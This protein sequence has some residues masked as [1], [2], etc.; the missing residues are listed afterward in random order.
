[1][2]GA[3]PDVLATIDAVLAN[4]TPLAGETPKTPVAGAAETP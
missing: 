4:H 3:L 2:H 1:L